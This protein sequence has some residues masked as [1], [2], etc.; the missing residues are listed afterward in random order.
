MSAAALT[1]A[2]GPEPV[3]VPLSGPVE[4]RGSVPFWIGLALHA[5]DFPHRMHLPPSGAAARAHKGR[6]GVLRVRA[7]KA[8]AEPE[9]QQE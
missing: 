2:F 6:E 9:Q 1:L 5:A 4:V 3:E 8:A 7:R